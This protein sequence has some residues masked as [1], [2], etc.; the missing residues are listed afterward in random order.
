MAELLASGAAQGAVRL[1]L[2]CGLL[3]LVGTHGA[4]ARLLPPP[5][6]GGPDWAAQARARVRRIARASEVLLALVVIARIVQQGSAFADTP[7]QW[8]TAVPLILQHTMWGRGWLLQVVSLAIVRVTSPEGTGRGRAVR[9]AALSALVVTPALSG[10]AIGAPRLSL[11]A[12]AMDA[13]HVL[14]AGAWVGTLAVMVLA[15]APL[16]HRV[17]ADSILAMLARFSPIALGSAAVVAA[18]GL[19]AGWLHLG[20]IDALW[21]TPYG[22]TLMLKLGFMAGVVAAGAF[23]W[24]VAT[25]RLADS[26]DRAP[27]VRAAVVEFVLALAVLVVTSLLIVTPLPAEG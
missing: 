11:V 27:L 5:H 25:P 21:G 22:R 19:F 8:P 7:A 18:T 24:R 16:R 6:E 3:L 13:L 12:V 4:L 14:V 2:L 17:P 23:N 10:H 9:L 26:G 15:L 20:T 1:A